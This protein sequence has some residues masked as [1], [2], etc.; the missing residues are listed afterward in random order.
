MKYIDITN[1]Q[2]FSLLI[3]TN[4]NS[5]VCVLVNSYSNVEI[6]KIYDH[7]ETD[8]EVQALESQNKITIT[9]PTPYNQGFAIFSG[10]Y[11]SVAL[12]SV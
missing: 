6:L 10:A 1:D 11:S 12:R 4:I 9:L 8:Y 3:V 7:G 5:A 2:Y